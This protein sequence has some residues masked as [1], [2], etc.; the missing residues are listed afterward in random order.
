VAGRTI[1][2]TCIGCR[3]MCD[4]RELVRL[5]VDPKEGLIV[6]PARMQGRGAYL[7]PSLHCLEKAWQRKVFTRAFRRGIP[8]LDEVTL[9]R[10]FEAELQRG[11]NLAA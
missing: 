1:V 10:R 2:R 7:C 5:A 4:R 8:G 3:R 9:R 6:N 11:G